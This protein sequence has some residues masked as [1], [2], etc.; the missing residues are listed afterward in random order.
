M[1]RGRFWIWV[2]RLARADFLGTLV[3][4]IFDWKTWLFGSVGGGGLTFIWAAIAGR[5]P[6]DVWIFALIAAACFAILIA[7]GLT[8]FQAISKSRTG[9]VAAPMPAN[10]LSAL[11]D[12]RSRE[13]AGVVS[14]LMEAALSWSFEL[15]LPAG[16]IWIKRYEELRDSAH[17]IWSD[18][19]ANQ[20]RREFLQYCGIVGD[21]IGSVH[22]QASD[23]KEL[24]LHGRNLMAKLKGE[25]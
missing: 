18:Q 10:E 15:P 24:A 25:R 4:F 21:P 8:I 14:A 22:E 9:T 1:S 3:S 6:L 16:D 19:E 2:D 23:R 20:L 11:I 5:D 17:P 7:V 12:D 13:L